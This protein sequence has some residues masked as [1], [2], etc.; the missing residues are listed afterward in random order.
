MA[1]CF[2]ETIEVLYITLGIGT[3]MATSLM[4]LVGYTIIPH[5]F[6]KKRGM[7]LGLT[8]AGVG[9][10]LF[11]FSALNG[12]LVSMYGVQGALLILTGV[13]L[14]VIPLGSLLHMPDYA[15]HTQLNLDEKQAELESLIGNRTASDNM[16]KKKV[17]QPSQNINDEVPRDIPDSNQTNALDSDIDN[18][19]YNKLRSCLYMLGFDLFAD[20]YFTILIITCLFICIPHNIVPTVLPDHM[21][22]TGTSKAEATATLMVIGIANTCGRLCVWNLSKENALIWM[23]ILAISSLI[24]G[25]SLACT[26]FYNEYW[27]YIV[28]CVLF[29]VTR[30]IYVIYFSLLLMH[31]VDTDRT[32]HAFGVSMTLAGIVLLVGMPGLG[33]LAEIT[34]HQW[35]YMVVFISAGACEIIAG[36]LCIIMRILYY[37]NQK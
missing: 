10:S 24:S 32:H 8:Q 5:Y 29:G 21:I 18:S 6:D 17:H 27:M 16:D 31:I 19:K 35:G 7:A 33:A 37:R 20:K 12:F 25:A 15:K 23:D 9:I 28:L 3:G 30:A 14:H 4:T 1:S 36:L 11:V 13:S 26:V 34:H 2:A 22:W